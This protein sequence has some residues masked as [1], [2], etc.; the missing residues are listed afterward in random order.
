MS[1]IL[2]LITRNTVRSDLV[3]GNEYHG[4]ITSHGQ[5]NY[6]NMMPNVSS[7][8]SQTLS[9][10]PSR[11]WCNI[12][13][14][15]YFYLHRKFKTVVYHLSC[16]PLGSFVV[17]GKIMKLALPFS[18]KKNSPQSFV[19]T[20]SICRRLRP[21]YPGVSLKFEKLYGAKPFEI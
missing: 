11:P 20:N 10:W 3:C 5:V 21:Q 9:S 18:H 4:S 19:V 2:L 8:S 6:N 16:V 15:V 13:K 17:N 1:S 14:S 7:P 12:C